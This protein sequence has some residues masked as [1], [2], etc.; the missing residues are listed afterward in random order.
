[1]D[2]ESQAIEKIR[3]SHPD[4]YVGEGQHAGQKWA[5]V[6]RENVV[7]VLRTLRDELGFS[8]LMD[9]TAVDYLDRGMP[10]RF[11]VVYQLFAIDHNTYF[12]VKTWVPE[13]DPIVDTASDVWK[14]APWAEREVWDMFGISF[15]G[16]KDLRR[17]L[18]PYDYVGHPLRKDYP[19]KGRGER[20]NFPKITR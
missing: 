2:L 8:M 1:M 11:C 10:E 4:A 12:R 6:K 7:E 18:T 14:S 19:L 5:F 3:A 15:R 13:D 20:F 9:L 17:I 16:N